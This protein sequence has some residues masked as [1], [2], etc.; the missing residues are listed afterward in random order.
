MLREESSIMRAL[1]I[2][3]LALGTAALLA[4]CGTTTP[5]TTRLTATSTCDAWNHASPGEQQVYIAHAVHQPIEGYGHYTLGSEQSFMNRWLSGGCKTATEAGNAE[6]TRLDDIASAEDAEKEVNGEPAEPTG[7]STQTP[8]TAA[9]TPA[10]PRAAPDPNSAPAFSL[11]GETEHGDKLKLEGRFGPVLAASASDVDQTVLSECP[12]YDER[13]LVVRLDL[14]TTLESGLS[15]TVAIAGFIPQIG[16]VYHLVDLVYDYTEGPS[17]VLDNVENESVIDLGTLQP[18]EPHDFTMWVVLLDAIT[19]RHPHPSV[20]TLSHQHWIIGEPSAAVN[21]AG[22]RWTHPSGDVAVVEV[23][24]V[25]RK[26]N[27]VFSR[28]TLTVQRYE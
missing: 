9:T 25:A 22:V 18:H 21:N 24:C 27:S 17:C 6:T 1:A 23:G 14:T 11:E 5:A 2:M 19:P 28:L 4:G 16:D 15:G 3:S 8:T 10:T 12:N 7:T 26:L 13:E 20:N